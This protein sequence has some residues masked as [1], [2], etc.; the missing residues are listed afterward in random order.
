[1]YYGINSRLVVSCSDRRFRV[2]TVNV[3]Y[4]EA[5]SMN[6]GVDILPLL[7]RIE[8]LKH[9]P[10]LLYFILL[11]CYVTDRVSHTSFL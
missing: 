5:S 4:T 11:V 6:G 8:Y 3:R 2:K 9:T 10:E 7:P 1:M